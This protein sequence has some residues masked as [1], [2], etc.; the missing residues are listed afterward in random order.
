M[1]AGSLLFSARGE[2]LPRRAL[3]L[4][5]L[6]LTA[7]PLAALVALPPLPVAMAALALAGLGT[8][9]INPLVFTVLQERVPAETRG[10]VFGTIIGTAMVA[11][12]LGI[13]AAGFLIEAMGLQTVVAI[14]AGGFLLVAGYAVVAPGFRDL[15]ASGPSAVEPAPAA[16]G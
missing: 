2:Q 1:L 6:V 3:L 8:G 11:A 9:P 15:D 14:V 5:G 7:L 10:R 16:D 13:A 12:P 4:G